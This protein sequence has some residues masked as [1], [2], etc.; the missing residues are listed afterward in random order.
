MKQRDL[1]RGDLAAANA[2]TEAWRGLKNAERDDFLA[3]LLR[4][5]LQFGG[6]GFREWLDKQLGK[7]PL[8]VD[9]RGLRLTEVDLARLGAQRLSG[10]GE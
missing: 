9:L 10:V 3:A 1:R 4:A 6:K 7:P 8:S 5:G 2:M